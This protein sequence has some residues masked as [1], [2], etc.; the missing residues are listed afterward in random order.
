MSDA[1]AGDRRLSLAAALGCVFATGVAIGLSLPLLSL[2]MDR[3]GHSDTVIGL[4]AAAQSLAMMAATLV[5]PKL[6]ARTGAAA[7]LLACHVAAAC[8]LVAIRATDALVLW[9]LLR[10]VLGAALQGIYLMSELWITQIAEADRRGRLLALYSAIVAGGY[11]M[12]PVILQTTGTTGWAPF[13]GGAVVILLG[14]APLLLA[15]RVVP[16]VTSAPARDVGR[17]LFVAPVAVFAGLTFGALET[18]MAAFLPLYAIRNGWAEPTAIL[19]LTAWGIGNIML[20]P[21]VG[22]LADRMN[23]Y[24]VLAGCA[25]AGVIGA[26]LLPFTMESFAAALTLLFFWGGVILGLYSVGL[27]VLGGRFTG[28][29]LSAANAAFALMYAGGSL[30]GPFLSGTAMDLWDPHGLLLVLGGIA[31]AYMILALLRSGRMA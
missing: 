28:G 23:P 19:L 31:F 14:A 18:G 12:G 13:A 22:W 4:S 9:F 25:A 21:A 24:R 8:A 2:M 7:F 17:Y 6:A 26:A 27:T 10:I 20:V 1:A 29:E 30:I 16:P 15:W 5:I 11:A 3:A